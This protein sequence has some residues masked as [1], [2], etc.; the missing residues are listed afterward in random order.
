M[1]VTTLWSAA[2][3]LRPRRPR[4]ALGAADDAL[5]RMAIAMAACN[6]AVPPGTTGG[7]SAYPTELALLD[8]ARRLGAS[9]SLEA[10]ERGRRAAVPHSTRS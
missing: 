7:P 2:R 3:T 1:Q 9:V 8:A 5:E 10:R 4:S 6:N